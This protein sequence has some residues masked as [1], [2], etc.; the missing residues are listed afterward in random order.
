LSAGRGSHWLFGREGGLENKA[1]NRCASPFALLELQPAG[2]ELDTDVTSLGG[3]V[4]GGWRWTSGRMT[5]EPLLGLSVVQS[6]FDDLRVPNGD[7]DPTRPHTTF[8]LDAAESTRASAGVRLGLD[9]LGS[10]AL[11][12]GLGL[13]A[14]LVNELEGSS[15]V[16][17]VNPGPTAQVEDT[18]Y[19][20][21]TQLTG[22]VGITNAKKA[23]EGYFNVDS[24]FN[25]D[26]SSF[27]GS[28]GIR[29]QW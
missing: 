11:P 29:L 24:T 27:G 4:E 21:F 15:E 25:D 10:A 20:T 13:T 9:R 14:R 5:V 16:S 2:T 26:Y 28:L 3:R 12:I 17:I 18:L 1:P 22:S 23:L 6:D 7:P 19:G 8:V